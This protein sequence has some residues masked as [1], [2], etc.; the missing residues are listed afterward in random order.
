MTEPLLRPLP[1]DLLSALLPV[2]AGVAAF[3][4][5]RRSHRFSRAAF[6]LGLL[7]PVGFIALALAT[8]WPEG[9]AAVGRLV[10]RLGGASSLCCYAALYLFGLL[11]QLPKRSLSSNF[12]AA[13][14]LLVG[15]LLLVEN[16]GPLAWRFSET[17][18]WRNAPD[19]LGHLTQTTGY[20][21][22]PASGTMLLHRYGIPASEGELAYLGGSSLFGTDAQ[23]MEDALSYLGRTRGLT[24]RSGRLD[25][26]AARALRRPFVAYLRIPEGGHAVFVERLTPEYVEL[27]DPRFGEPQIM[28]RPEFAGYW[29]GR[30]VWLDR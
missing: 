10:H 1:L 15:V 19:E 14:S 21:C 22:A 23:G 7:M 4:L 3:A 17:P 12:L 18:M 27:I 6:A 30:A 29:D 9:D 28:P 13:M 24:A 2:T 20:T 25:Y 11:W 16:G 5:G 26:D 8:A